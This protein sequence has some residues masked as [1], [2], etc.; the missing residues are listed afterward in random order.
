MRRAINSSPVVYCKECVF[1]YKPDSDPCFKSYK[2]DPESL[3]CYWVD[4]PG[5]CFCSFG[6]KEVTDVE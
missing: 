4:T 1:K 3:W 6:R 2:V 5:D